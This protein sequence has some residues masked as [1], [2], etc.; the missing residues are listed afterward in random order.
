MIILLS[1]FFKIYEEQ[2][3]TAVSSAAVNTLISIVSSGN[4]EIRDSGASQEVLSVIHSDQSLDGLTTSSVTDSDF[5]GYRNQLHNRLAVD[6]SADEGGSASVV[7]QEH[8]SEVTDSQM[9]RLVEE[10]LGVPDLSASQSFSSLEGL[11]LQASHEGETNA[12]AVEG[13]ANVSTNEIVTLIRDSVI[14][15]GVME[16][17]VQGSPTLLLAENNHD[18]NIAVSYTHL[19]LPTKA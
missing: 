18:V 13:T 3:T 5:D 2:G 10:H 11:D 14:D 1:S 4:E 12:F 8:D 16:G 15:Y 9:T 19:T 6:R 17:D 7:W